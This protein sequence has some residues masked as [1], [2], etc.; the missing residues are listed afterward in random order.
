MEMLALARSTIAFTSS[1]SLARQKLPPSRPLAAQAPEARP[2][3]G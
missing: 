3:G 1:R 2:G